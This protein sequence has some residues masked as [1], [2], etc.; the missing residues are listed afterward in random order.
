MPRK[1]RETGGKEERNCNAECIKK[2]L[3]RVGEWKNYRLK[4]LETADRDTPQ[5][6][7]NNKMQFYPSLL[8]GQLLFWILNSH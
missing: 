3:E 7:N 6:N 1:W 5:E 2:K 8:S 4:E